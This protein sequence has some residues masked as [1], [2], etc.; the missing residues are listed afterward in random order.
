MSLGQLRILPEINKEPIKTPSLLHQVQRA[1]SVR[2]Q[3]LFDVRIYGKYYN[4]DKIPL[5]LQQITKNL[6][7]R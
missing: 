7:K 5:F 4:F 3:D 2:I 6:L 1:N